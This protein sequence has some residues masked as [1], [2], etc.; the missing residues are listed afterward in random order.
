LLQNQ[1]CHKRAGNNEKN[2]TRKDESAMAAAPVALTALRRDLQIEDFQQLVWRCLVGFVLVHDLRKKRM[3]GASQIQK[4]FLAP[5]VVFMALLGLGQA[6]AHFFDGQAF[7]M[8]SAPR[9][10]VDP[11][12]TFLCVALLIHGW[13]QY[14]FKAPTQPIFTLSIAGLVFVLWV[15]PQVFFHAASRTDGFD[16]AFFGGGWRYW[17]NIEPRWMRLVIVVPLLE[18]IFWRGFLLRYLIREPFEEVPVGAFSWPSCAW[19]ALFFAAAHWGP[20]FFPALLTGMLYNFIAYRTR[21]LSSCVLAHAVTNLL[22]GIYIF[23]TGQW[24]FW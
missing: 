7:W 10:W 1:E 11:L 21:S 2:T 6:V 20:D 4:A 9:Y 22:L 12:Q 13:R 23:V 19:V 17:T 5:F 14:E 16:P 18:E 24:G 3:F 15:S 8:A